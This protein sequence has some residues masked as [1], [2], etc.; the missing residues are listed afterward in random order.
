MA[1]STETPGE[2][3]GEIPGEALEGAAPGSPASALESSPEVKSGA[4]A[5]HTILVNVW[6]D[7]R[8]PWCYLG[9]RRLEQAIQSFSEQHPNI[10]VTVSHHSFE[11]APDMPER[12]GGSEAE[13]LLRYEGVPLEQS[14]RTLPALRELA[15]AEGVELRF[16]DL[17]EVNTRRAHRVFQLGR[18]QGL[19]EELLEGLFAAYFR[20]CRDLADPLILADIAAQVGLPYDDALAAATGSEHWDEAVS[21]DHMRGQM[22]GAA[23]VP[24]ALINA[25]Y[26]ISGA[27]RREVFAAAL[28]EVARREFNA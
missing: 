1:E 21:S 20:E 9:K 12:F 14:E 13:Y 15:A 19:G 23:G 2:A 18:Q 4:S 5:T 25:K 6:F 22:V 8:C 11:L 26:S 7:V 27:H 3:P 10:E 17:I 24:F 28:E 16:D